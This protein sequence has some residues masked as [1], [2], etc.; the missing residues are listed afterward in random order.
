MQS[1][2]SVGTGSNR[3]ASSGSTTSLFHTREPAAARSG[4]HLVHDALLYA[5]AEEY[6]EGVTRLALEGVE[7][8][9]PVLIAVPEPRLGTLTAALRGADGAVAFVD[10]R[11]EG[12]NPARILPLIQAFV[13]EHP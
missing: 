3:S 8:N 11:H 5:D 7:A 13:D 6:V 9:E 4:A 12:R 1:G 2:P 10:M